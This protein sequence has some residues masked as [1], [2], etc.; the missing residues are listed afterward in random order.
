MNGEDI[1]SVVEMVRNCW[2]SSMASA[3]CDAA[4]SRCGETGTGPCT[5]VSGVW[6]RLNGQTLCVFGPADRTGG[7]WMFWQLVDG[8]GGY[9]AAMT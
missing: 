7:A 3:R 9:P 2:D 4:R 6:P 1:G 8:G 5:L